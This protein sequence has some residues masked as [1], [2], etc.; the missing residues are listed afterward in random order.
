MP[1]FKPPRRGSMND[2]ADA[3]TRLTLAQGGR[4]TVWLFKCG[5]AWAWIA[6]SSFPG[7]GNV[8]AS[9]SSTDGWPTD[10]LAVAAALLAIRTKWERRPNTPPQLLA[11]IDREAESWEPLPIARTPRRPR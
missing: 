7:H 1:T 5:R 2:A 6:A 11:A 8:E 9:A 4:A 3:I 10:Y